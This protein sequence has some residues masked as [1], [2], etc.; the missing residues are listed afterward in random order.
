MNLNNFK[1]ELAKYVLDENNYEVGTVLGQGAFGFVYEG[2][3]LLT[4]TVV[5]IKQVN[6]DTMGAHSWD[7]I[8]KQ[9]IAYFLICYKI[10]V[11][12]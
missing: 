3:E 4:N 2:I 11:L 7:C 9:V 10:S 6:I 1:D 12:F 8:T 5:A